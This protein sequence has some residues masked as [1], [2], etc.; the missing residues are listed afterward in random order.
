[1]T[2]A[3]TTHYRSRSQGFNSVEAGTH[4]PVLADRPLEFG[5][6]GD[7]V[8]SKWLRPALEVLCRVHDRIGMLE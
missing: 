1:M 6:L 2:E 5:L 3:S 4:P 8:G 7:A